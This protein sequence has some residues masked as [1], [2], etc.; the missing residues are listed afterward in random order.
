MGSS[1]FGISSIHQ[2]VGLHDPVWLS[3]VVSF[4]FCVLPDRPDLLCAWVGGGQLDHGVAHWNGGD[5]LSDQLWQCDRNC[6]CPLWLFS[7][8]LGFWSWFTNLQLTVMFQF[9]Y[10]PCCLHPQTAEI[11]QSS[12][13]QHSAW[14]ISSLVC[15][16]VQ[17]AGHVVHG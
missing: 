1:A 12:C 3:V 17:T 7:A 16:Q 2:L 9:I 8:V 6:A 10:C 4:Q 15:G 5:G 14:V 13:Q 11:F